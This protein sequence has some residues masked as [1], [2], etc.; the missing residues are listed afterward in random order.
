MRWL[1]AWWVRVWDL[2]FAEP[3]ES[4]RDAYSTSERGLW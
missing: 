2:V 3:P 1:R 4:I